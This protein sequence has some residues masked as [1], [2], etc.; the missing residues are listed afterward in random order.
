MNTMLARDKVSNV[1]PVVLFGVF[2][3]LLPMTEAVHIVPIILL[4]SYF[5]VRGLFTP[6]PSVVS[7]VAIGF[8]F[9]LPI[10]ISALNALDVERTL[11]DGFRI[12]LYFLAG[13]ILLKMA[14]KPLGK[15][16]V[17]LLFYIVLLVTIIWSLDAILQYFSGKNILGYE[18]NDRRVTGLFHPKMRIGIVLAHL[19]PFVIEACRRLY[20][21]TNKSAVWL[22]LVPIVFVILVGGSRSSWVVATLTV[23]FYALFFLKSGFFSKKMIFIGIIS[24]AL[25]SVVSYIKLPQFQDRV[26]RTVQIFE[27]TESSLN[28]ATARRGEV[29]GAAWF[30]F[31]ENPV[32]GIGQGA[33]AILTEKKD[34]ASRGYP[35]A[36]FFALDILMY[37]GIIGFL[38]YA[39]A[40]IILLY[41]LWI[42]F[43]SVQYASF[44]VSLSAV[45]MTFPVNTHWGF[46]S[47]LSSSIM[48]M[49]I[50]YSFLDFSE[51]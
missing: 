2:I 23:L 4:I 32:N 20:L 29:W 44:S 36:H 46:Y 22:L 5:F 49:L 7:Y 24:V 45:L 31:K 6:V 47:V 19:L 13:Y 3:L 26:D 16:A 39:I 42:R 51:K 41:R 14:S 12:G 1:F 11:I 34:L 30:L 37:A 35:H 40:Y 33:K 15:S 28:A 38:M 21:H 10:F 9:V 48:C 25:L 43:R 18:Y 50:I 8:L 17:D 27:M